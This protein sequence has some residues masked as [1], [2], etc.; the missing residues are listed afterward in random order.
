MAKSKDKT[1]KQKVEES[2]LIKYDFIRIKKEE[3]IML[4]NIYASN[5]LNAYEIGKSKFKEDKIIHVK[6]IGSLAQYNNIY[7]SMILAPYDNINENEKTK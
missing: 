5:L 7:R 6:Y 4:F 1:P 3:D 2:K